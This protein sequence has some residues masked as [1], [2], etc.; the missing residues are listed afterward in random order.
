[1]DLLEKEDTPREKQQLHTEPEEALTQ[2]NHPSK[3]STYSL[4]TVL[5]LKSYCMQ[6][7]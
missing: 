7:K 1:M 6:N 2:K 4:L 3:S 5:Y